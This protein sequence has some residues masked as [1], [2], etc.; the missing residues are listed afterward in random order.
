MQN[1]TAGKWYYEAGKDNDTAVSTRVRLARNIA[2]YPFPQRMTAEQKKEL[3]KKVCDALI[4]SNSS[5]GGSFRKIDME[6]VTDTAAL[7][8]AERHLISPQFASNR[9]GKCLLL[10]D[11]ESISIMLCEED[12]LRIQVMKSGVCVEE[13]LDLAKKID[14]LINENL[15]YAFDD[16]LGYLTACPTNLGTGMRASVM[17]HLPALASLNRVGQFASA[18]SKIGLTLRGEFGE[19]SKAGGAL[20]QLSNE[21]TLGISEESAA[22]NLVSIAN[23]VIAKDREARGEFDKTDVEDKSL[24]AAAILKNARV[25]S[26]A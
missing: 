12:H 21:I 6:D 17:L 22:Q 10:L 13:C 5:I 11:D 2:G 18:V 8:M 7:A 20:Y 9:E 24:R 4:G 26:S 14:E 3:N 19:G 23:Q 1:P 25:L 16:K 15:T